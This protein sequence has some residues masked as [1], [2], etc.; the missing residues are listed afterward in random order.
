M[1]SRT[2]RLD[3]WYLKIIHILHRRY[4]PRIIGHILRNKQK[5]KYVCIHEIM[6][7][8]IMKMNMKMKNRSHR[9]NINKPRPSHEQ[10]YS[11]YQVSQHDDG[12]MY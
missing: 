9:Y 8:I 4:H 11:K 6:R 5:N 10:K 7:L 1:L 2:L 12:Y 3:F